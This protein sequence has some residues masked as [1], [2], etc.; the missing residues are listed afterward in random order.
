MARL[1]GVF[2]V[3]GAT[4]ALGTSA[5][6]AQARPDQGQK[7]S[8]RQLAQRIV[9]VG[10]PGALVAARNANGIRVGAAGYANLRTKERMRPAHAFRVG[11]ITKTFVATVVLQLAGD[12]VLRLDDTVERWLPG[13]VP[14]GGAIT[15]RHLLNHTSGLYNYTDD[16]AL[17]RLAVDNRLRAFTP[18]ELLAVALRRRPL[19][20]P[21]AQWSYSNTGYILLGL[22]VEKATGSTVSDQ[23]RTRIFEP[24]GLTRTSFPTVA[25]LSP[26]FAHGY[27]FPGNGI[28]P[29][30]GNRRADVTVWNPSWA[31]SA[32]AVVSTADDLSRFYGALLGG[33]VLRPDLLAEMMRTVGGG[34]PGYGLGLARVNLPC[35]EA[36][37]HDG[38]VPGYTS[39]AFTMKDGSRQV[40]VLVSTSIDSNRVAARIGAAVSS[41]FCR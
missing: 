17:I 9:D 3:L 31:W 18:Q 24:M 6:T 14:N 15:L 37:G 8:L 2:L 1:R 40:V 21:G 32:G 41:G 25:A 5:S 39:I 11:S 34:S 36:W 30:R 33:S 23:L 10:A 20:A 28:I 22:V 29:I 27:V 12:G 16:P 35:G 13:V 19:F 7:L 4:L 38:L 26:P